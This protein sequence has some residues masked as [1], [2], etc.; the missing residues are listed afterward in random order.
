MPRASSDP[1]ARRPRPSTAAARRGHEL[2]SAATGP[3]DRT[4]LLATLADRGY[5][6]ATD[7]V[8]A[9]RL[10]NCPFDRLATDHRELT[11]SLNLAMLPAIAEDFGAAA[12]ETRAGPIDGFCC[13]AF[14]PIEP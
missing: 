3:R 12:V 7:G 9:I 1:T 13:V 2:A 6:P 11:C 5:E 10:R 14:V 4:G 8:G